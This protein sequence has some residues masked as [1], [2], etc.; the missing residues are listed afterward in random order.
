MRVEEKE[1]HTKKNNNLKQIKTGK[2]TLAGG[3]GRSAPTTF[4][5]T[6]SLVILY[7]IR[8]LTTNNEEEKLDSAD[9]SDGK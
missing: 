9:S 1:T 6:F 8:D 4:Q 3:G 7:I 5:G 2:P